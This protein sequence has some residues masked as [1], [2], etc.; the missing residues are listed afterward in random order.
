MTNQYLQAFMDDI[1][2]ITVVCDT[3]QVDIL[4]ISLSCDVM[5]TL[6]SQTST[7]YT[8]QTNLPLPLDTPIFAIVNGEKIPVLFRYIARLPLFDDYFYYD[9]ILGYT[10]TPEQTEFKL[11]A[12]GATQVYLL[13]DDVP[14]EMIKQERGVYTYTFLGN[15]LHQTYMYGIYRHTDYH[16]V[17]DP[18]TKAVTVNGERGVIVTVPTASKVPLPP[19]DVPIIYE[20]HVR[21]MSSHIDSG[22][23]HKGM[24]LGLTEHNTH[25]SHL[26]KTGIDYMTS[27]GVTHVQ[28]MPMADY[29]AQSVDETQPWRSYNWGY[30]PLHFNVPEGSYSTNPYDPMTRILECQAFIDK[31]HQEGLRVIM[32]VVYNHVYHIKEHSFEKIVPF[33]F[34]RRDEYGVLTDGTGVGNDF[35]SERKMARKYIVDSVSYWAQTYQIDGFR[36]DLMGM[37][38]IQ[39]MQDVSRRLKAINP[40]IIILGEGWDMGTLPTPQK[41]M[42]ANAHLISDIAF[43]ND[44]FRDN[45]KSFV[46]GQ[47]GFEGIIF[48]QIL[49]TAP[50]TH[51]NQMV[52]YVEVHDNYTLWDYL[53]LH[54]TSENDT[55]RLKRHRL[56]TSMVLL[57]FGIPFLHAGQ[58]FMRT[59]SGIENSYCSPDIINQMDWDRAFVY[60]DNIEYVTSL[61]HF[62]KEHPFFATT[63]FDT[64]KEMVKLIKSDEQ[65][66]AYCVKDLFIIHSANFYGKDLYLPHG[67]YTLLISSESISVKKWIVG[68]KGITV[69]P[70]ST[71]V[72]K[73][74]R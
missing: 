39:T 41:A 21:D 40:H 16:E 49:G 47:L 74:E 23:Q 71:L 37:L 6:V 62:R 2:R 24:F 44:K 60:Q 54:N 33:Y 38:D 63:D 4:E 13:L 28:M 25:T 45:V 14:Y 65:I 18:Y 46:S 29:S 12:P 64:I 73:K 70:L 31:C 30:D 53:T 36:F 67:T 26:Q 55:I 32:D 8:Y 69:P 1:D 11:W 50:Y 9:G 19:V 3:P 57:T 56:A 48:N 66:I 61:V 34:F 20:M 15:C 59:K 43:F 27:L 42:Q 10:Y 68:S 51:M 22:I 72:L 7:S 52:Q 5:I 58:E 17:V 35:A